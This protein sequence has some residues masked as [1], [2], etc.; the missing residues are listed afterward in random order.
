MGQVASGGLVTAI[1]SHC[2]LL[3]AHTHWESVWPSYENIPPLIG[4]IYIDIYGSFIFNNHIGVW[5]SGDGS[6]SVL[7]CAAAPDIGACGANSVGPPVDL[8]ERCH[9]SKNGNHKKNDIITCIYILVYILLG[10][11]LNGTGSLAAQQAVDDLAHVSMH[12]PQLGTWKRV[13]NSIIRELI[14]EC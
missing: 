1:V 3:S 5:I 10:G 4:Y 14:V 7:G 11:I 8:S 13:K 6:D 12:P 2:L 9:K